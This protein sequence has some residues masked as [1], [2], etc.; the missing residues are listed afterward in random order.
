M[1]NRSRFLDLIAFSS[2][3]FQIKVLVRMIESKFMKH[4]SNIICDFFVLKIFNI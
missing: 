4:M 1:R 3:I 2:F